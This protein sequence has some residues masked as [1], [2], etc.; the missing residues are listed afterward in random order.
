MQ[1]VHPHNKIVSLYAL[2]IPEGIKENCKKLRAD[3]VKKWELAK[4]DK[5]K[6]SLIAELVGISRATYYRYREQVK[7]DAF[8]FKSKAP[9]ILKE[10]RFGQDVRD[11][12]QQIR[13]EEP[14]YGKCKIAAILKRD[15][16]VQIGASSVGKILKELNVPRSLSALRIKRA[17]RFEGHAQPYTFKPYETMR[18]GER[19][20][21]DH[22]SVTKNG[23]D[24]KEFS[25]WDRRSKTLFTNA[26]PDADS[27]TAAKFLNEAKEAL[28]FLILSAQVDGGS[29]FQGA[30]EKECAARHIPLYVLPPATPKYNGGVEHSNRTLREEFYARADLQAKSLEE[31]R[32]ELAKF[33][34]KYN[35][36][37]P[38]EG[39]DLLAPAEYLALTP[40]E[41][42]KVDEKMHAKELRRREKK[43]QKS[44]K[45]SQNNGAA[46]QKAQGS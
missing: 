16:K 35:E 23:E 2:N 32:V 8:Q 27:E 17:R 11:L 30:F 29:E 33:M 37:R 12:V 19:V 4:K 40:E 46:E 22:M 14:T 42:K 15:H 41:Q 39:I 34:K 13:T 7:N 18:V 36:Y 20:Q 1:T 3:L 6:E 45:T 44:G 43:L 21:I 26:Y 31:V 10:S 24:Y 28:P 9:K 38:H 5:V 25:L